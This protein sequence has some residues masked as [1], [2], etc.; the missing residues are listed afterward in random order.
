MERERERD[1]LS[2]GTAAL[3]VDGMQFI[4]TVV[5]EAH[6]IQPSRDLCEQQLQ[7][8]MLSQ[9]KFI[10]L[11]SP[12]SSHQIGRVF[13]NQIHTDEPYA[14][15]IYIQLIFTQASYGIL[16]R[17]ANEANYIYFNGKLTKLPDAAASII[18][19]SIFSEKITTISIS[20]ASRQMVANL[21]FLANLSNHLNCI[22]FTE[23]VR[24]KGPMILDRW[25]S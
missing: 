10:Y 25:E 3:S 5:T 16:E 12:S 8:H 1:I 15:S 20:L 6:Q 2:S 21:L 13:Q 7:F 4:Y 18:H 19:L 17:L 14:I 11:S 23:L 9:L 24:L 22:S